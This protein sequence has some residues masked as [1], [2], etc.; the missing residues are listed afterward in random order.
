MLK[1]GT[2]AFSEKSTQQQDQPN[3]S[4]K[5][6]VPKNDTWRETDILFWWKILQW[7]YIVLHLEYTHNIGLKCISGMVLNMQGEYMKNSIGVLFQI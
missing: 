3:V 2:K 6:A 1:I 5:K 4:M 7:R